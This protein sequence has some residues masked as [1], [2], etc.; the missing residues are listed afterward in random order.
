MELTQKQRKAL[1]LWKQ[2]KKNKE[3]TEKLGKKP[4]SAYYALTSGRKKLESTLET[5]EWAAKR[6]ILDHT[7]I[8]RLEKV[9]EKYR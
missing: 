2:G 3:I 5:I 8:K 7:Y 9:L 4:S 6:K 1:L